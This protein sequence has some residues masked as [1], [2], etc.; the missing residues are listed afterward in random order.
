M[1]VYVYQFNDTLWCNSLFLLVCVMFVLL[2]LNLQVDLFR[3]ITFRNSKKTYRGIPIMASNMD[4][5]GTFNMA[6]VL[7]KVNKNTNI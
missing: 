6:K 2:F 1:N 4:T 5:I 7:S 3:E